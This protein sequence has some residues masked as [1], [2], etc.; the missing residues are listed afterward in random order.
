MDI[1]LRFPR[2][3]PKLSWLAE[4]WLRSTR[5]SPRDRDGTS[6]RTRG[7]LVREL[8][9]GA[10]AAAVFPEYDLSPE[11]KYPIAIEQ[12][13]AVAPWVSTHGAEK[14]LDSSRFAVA[15]MPCTESEELK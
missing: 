11:A 4:T 14:G 8:A 5:R 13:Y 3:V 7:R 1:R 10:D 9:V 2:P 6:A 15:G 12:N